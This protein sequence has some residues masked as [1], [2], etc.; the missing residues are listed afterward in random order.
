M[1]VLVL[2]L[3]TMPA[4][5]P[6]SASEKQPPNIVMIL[7]DDQ[8]WGDLSSSGNT[9]LATPN[10]DTLAS[11]GARFQHFYVSPVCSP[12]RAEMLTGRYHPR[13]GVYGTS[14]GGELLDLDE[15][16]IAE[17]FKAAGYATGAFGKWH[18]GMQPPYHPNARGFD[19]FYGFCSG[20]WGD[21][22]SPNLL[23]RNGRLVKGTGYLIDDF[24]DH[25]LAFIEE[26]KDRPFFAYLPYNTPHSP[27]Q[28]PDRWW[29]KFEDSELPLRHRDP[30]LE[31]VQHTRAA[32]AMVENIDWNVGRVM[33]KLASLGLEEETIVIY[34]SDNGPNGYR[35]NGGMKG[36][37]GSTD[38]GGVRSPFYMR[39][40]GA[41]EPGQVVE[42]IA[43]AI[44]LLPTLADLAD[45]PFEASNP[46]DGVSLV[47]LLEGAEHWPDRYI[48]SYWN[49]RTSVRSQQYRL[50]HENQLFDMTAD[51]EQRENVAELLPA[52]AEELGTAKRQWQ[53]EVLVDFPPAEG[54]PYPVG[55]PDYDFTQLPVRDAT[56]TGAIERSNRFPNDSFFRNWVNPEDEIRWDVD[57]LTAGEYEV[58]LYYACPEEDLGSTIELSM[59]EQS[60]QGTVA[61]ANDPPLRG[62]END[63]DPRQES[64]VK[65]F[66]PMELGAIQLEQGRGTLR[67]RALDMPGSQVMEV[68]LMMLKRR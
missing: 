57:V 59:G 31:N 26:N 36:R 4:C 47:P 67:L 8:G 5:T 35:W 18:N 34:F 25:A 16:T 32:L 46:L 63:R 40:K 49:G 43:G 54:R 64:Y 17:V 41:I 6:E 39:W 9:N 45:I 51:P 19:E 38:E 50:G 42:E 11:T 52:V 66:A 29:E 62:A 48:F 60:L 15:Q 10:I 61:V 21:Y 14:A 24:T 28:V 22:F 68:R 44:D 2:F 53:Q 7:A 3:M 20:H 65:D 1:A 27:M 58:V 56:A 33:E 37:K 30:D 12:T 55:H 13:G 23:E